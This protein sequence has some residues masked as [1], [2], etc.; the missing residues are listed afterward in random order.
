MAPPT[1]SIGLVREI[2]PR[3]QVFLMGQVAVLRNSELVLYASVVSVDV[4]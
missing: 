2:L 1:T 4:I 3:L